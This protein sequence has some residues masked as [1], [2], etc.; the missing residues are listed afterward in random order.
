MSAYT[1]KE[2]IADQYECAPDNLTISHGEKGVVIGMMNTALKG[3]GTYREADVKRRIVLGWLFRD[4]LG[5]PAASEVST[6]DLTDRMWWALYKYVDPQFH[7][8]DGHW[9][10]RPNL[11][12]E[13]NE[14]L[15][16]MEEW[17]REMQ[18]QLNFNL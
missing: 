13:M 17:E 16:V 3:E 11:D 10:G 1:V 15:K 6:K 18:Q 5:K 2:I 4:L 12:I 7:E 9:Y 14:C 8:D